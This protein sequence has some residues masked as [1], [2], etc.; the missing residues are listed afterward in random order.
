[1]MPTCLRKTKSQGNA[2]TVTPLSSNALHFCS[3]SASQSMHSIR[4]Q[5]NTVR[6]TNPLRSVHAPFSRAILRP[7]R[8]F[9]RQGGRQ[10][11]RMAIFNGDVVADDK[12]DSKEKTAAASSRGFAGLP[13]KPED[14]RQSTPAASKFMQ[15]KNCPKKHT[16]QF[17][18]A[19]IHR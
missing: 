8:A 14:M 9:G 13:E 4:C 10:A 3:F 15:V 5:G 12:L 7:V 17:C 1:M 2:P 19:C 6:N 16:T 11:K 18:N